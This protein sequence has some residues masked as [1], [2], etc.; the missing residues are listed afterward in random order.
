MIDQVLVSA[1]FEME[2]SLNTFKK[3][4]M[5]LKTIKLK[6]KNQIKPQLF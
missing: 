2:N 4:F 5:S 6:W 1:K 3:R